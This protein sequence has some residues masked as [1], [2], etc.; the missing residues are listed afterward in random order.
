MTAESGN[1]DYDP[2]SLSLWVIALIALLRIKDSN[3]N[4]AVASEFGID[5][6]NI[7]AIQG[8]A[9]AKFKQFKQ[10]VKHAIADH[11][12]A[13]RDLY[14][15]FICDY[16]DICGKDSKARTNEAWLYFP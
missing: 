5:L 4:S 2:S 12:H 14:K 15:G 3:R 7:D 9:K 13:N 16:A 1:D 10:R 6:E 11:I 8:L